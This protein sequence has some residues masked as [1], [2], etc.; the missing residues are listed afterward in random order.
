M[1]EI[2]SGR[3]P[4]IGEIDEKE[5]SLPRMA[6]RQHREIGPTKE[7]SFLRGQGTLFRRYLGRLRAIPVVSPLQT[8]FE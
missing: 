8:L 5:E 6:A 1:R 7:Q 2:H 4:K 3:Y